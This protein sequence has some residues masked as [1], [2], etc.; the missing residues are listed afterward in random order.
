[1]YRF[2]K[3]TQ[4]VDEE[5]D[6]LFDALCTEVIPRLLRPLETGG[7]FIEPCLVHSNLWPGYCMSDAD[8][9]E[10]MIF[11]SCAFWGHNEAELG[12]GCFMG[13]TSPWG[14]GLTRPHGGH[15]GVFSFFMNPHGGGGINGWGP[16]G[17]IAPIGFSGA[18]IHLVQA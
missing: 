13:A 2:E 7:R 1:M 16:W 11:D 8:T 15:M 18:V 9:G 14:W 6:G 5:L 10:I 12:L 3:E 17:P 4:G